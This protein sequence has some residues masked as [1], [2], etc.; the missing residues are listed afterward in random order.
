MKFTTQQHQT[1]LNLLHQQSNQGAS[2]SNNFSHINQ[3]GTLSSNNHSTIGNVL[4]FA[5]AVSKHDQVIW[6]LDSRAT[7]HVAPSLKLYTTYKEIPSIVVRLPNQQKTLATHS[8]V[9]QLTGSLI[10]TNVL[11]L[12]SFTF[13]L[14][15]ISKLASSLSCKLIFCA[16]KCLIQDIANQKMIGTI[17]VEDGLYKLIS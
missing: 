17:D 14:V 12:P 9:V 15:S 10:L 2:T 1:L 11:H 4:P 8:R 7:D 3:I 13:N 16:N 6:I 5:R